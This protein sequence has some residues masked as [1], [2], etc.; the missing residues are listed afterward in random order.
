[1]VNYACYIW[2]SIVPDTVICVANVRGGYGKHAISQD[3]RSGSRTLADPGTL[4]R[5]P[6]DGTQRDGSG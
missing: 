3:I 6:W 4:R 5:N 2:D 1:M